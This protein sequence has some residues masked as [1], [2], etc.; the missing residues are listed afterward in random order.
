MPSH[1]LWWVTTA[2]L[3]AVRT[4]MQFAQSSRSQGCGNPAPRRLQIPGQLT[5]W[6]CGSKYGCAVCSPKY[7]RAVHRDLIPELE[8]WLDAGWQWHMVTLT[9]PHQRSDDPEELVSV[10]LASV[11]SFE[12]VY[13]G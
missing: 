2:E 1:N 6:T 13:D 9:V 8:R 4:E 5:R 3:R 10:L 7:W 12:V 11:K